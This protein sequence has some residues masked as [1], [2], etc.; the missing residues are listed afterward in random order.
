MLKKPISWLAGD[1]TETILQPKRNVGFVSLY[2]LF[3][4]SPKTMALP[5]LCL[6]LM[7]IEVMA[8]AWLV[9]Q[10]GTSMLRFHPRVF[11][12]FHSLRA[13]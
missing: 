8:G 3:S 12:T 13:P 4:D 10:P 1:W 2:H 5:R 11:D 6:L 7:T 9:E